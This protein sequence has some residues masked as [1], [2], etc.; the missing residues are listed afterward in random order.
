MKE[1]ILMKKELVCIPLLFMF[2][3]S[4]DI[5][6]DNRERLMSTRK[7]EEEE[8]LGVRDEA[9]ATSAEEEQERFTKIDDAYLSNKKEHYERL[10]EK[11]ARSTSAQE[12][13]AHY[14]D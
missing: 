12:K 10:G 3:V 14:I 2:V 11:D 9:A 7:Q 13:A 1:K 6:T 5:L 8:R 4:L